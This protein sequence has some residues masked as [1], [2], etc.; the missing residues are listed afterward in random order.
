MRPWRNEGYRPEPPSAEYATKWLIIAMMASA[1]A[2]LLLENTFGLPVT[3]AL[4][5]SASRLSRGAVWQ[6]VTYMFL[7]A[8]LLHLI[9]NLLMLWWF[10]SLVEGS[11]GRRS[12][13]ELFF[14]AGIFGGLVQAAASVF[15]GQPDLITLGCSGGLLGVMVV[16]A[17]IAPSLTVFFSFVIPMKLRTMVIICIFMDLYVA[18]SGQRSGTAVLAHLG[19]AAFGYGYWKLCYCRGR[20]LSRFWEMP[21]EKLRSMFQANQRVSDSELDEILLKVGREGMKSLSRRERRILIKASK[22]KRKN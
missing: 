22:Q 19:G 7:H 8:G 3:D 6:P 10:G 2:A 1:L 14:G 12:Y 21:L 13:L 15:T 9:F 20:S 18:L 5:L 11:I 17:M 16:C 4:A